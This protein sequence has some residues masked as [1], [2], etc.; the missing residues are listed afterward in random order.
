MDRS[1]VLQQ[2]EHLAAL[3][4]AS[5]DNSSALEAL[6]CAQKV[7][8]WAT[9]RTAALRRRIRETSVSPT[10]ARC[11]ADEVTASS[12]SSGQRDE[13]RADAAGAVPEVQDAL[14]LGSITA[15]HVDVIAAAL[16]SL[17]PDEQLLLASMGR[18]LVEQAMGVNPDHYRANLRLL[19]DRMRR[20]AGQRLRERQKRATQL[21]VWFDRDTGMWCLNGRLDP[22]LAATIAQQL[23]SALRSRFSQATPDLCPT[24]P[25]AKASWLRAHALADVF[26]A[27]LGGGDPSTGGGRGGGGG[28]GS[29]EVTVVITSPEG[30]IDTGLDG[31]MCADAV[32]DLIRRG[33]ARLFTV[34]TEDGH[35][36]EAPG[37]LN[38]GRTTRVANAA[39]RRAL[40]ALYPT[41][42]MPGCSVDYRRCR[43]HHVHWWRFG[44]PT[45]LGNLLPVCD[46]HHNAI[47]QEGWEVTLGPHR[48]LTVVRPD[49]RV[50]RTGP[51]GR[52]P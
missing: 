8:S 17:E 46:G 47:H 13:L 30:R 32:I 33:V 45:D 3:D 35:V 41:C 6:T 48:E 11:D 27:A 36:I 44:G 37:R 10:V 50:M 21:N 38:L 31:A 15:E 51:P 43:H 49:G 9:G 42:A 14:D 24:D 23:D 19:V 25:R 40:H 4:V 52:G 7:Q 2:V 22:E 5:L 20:D 34:V 26:A 1:R 18:H 28:T 39:Q 12:R 29:A 16:S